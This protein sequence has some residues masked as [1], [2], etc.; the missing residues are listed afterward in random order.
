MTNLYTAHNLRVIEEQAFADIAPFALMQKAASSILAQILALSER[1]SSILI[2]AGRGNNGGDGLVLAALASFYGIEATVVLISGS[3]STGTLF[4]EAKEYAKRALVKVELFCES[5]EYS[6]SLL[7]DA[8]LG[9]GLKGKP[10]GE[11]AKAIKKFNHSRG[12]KISCDVPSG[13]CSDTGRTYDG[14]CVRADFTVTFIAKKVGLV[15]GD[16]FDYSGK[17]ILAPLELAPL[18]HK[19]SPQAIERNYLEFVNRLPMRPR[20][21]HK[22]LF[23]HVVVVAGSET[24]AGAALLAC[25]AA[26]RVGAGLVTLV[27][28][29]SHASSLHTKLAELMII[30]VGKKSKAWQLSSLFSNADV[31]L[32]GPG[33]RENDLWSEERLRE[34]LQFKGPKVLDAGGLS[35]LAKTTFETLENTVITPHPGEAKALLG[36][37]LFNDLTRIECVQELAKHYCATVV[38]KGAGPL[39]YGREQATPSLFPIANSALATAGSG[40]VFAG[41][42]AGFLAQGLSPNESAH[43]ALSLQQK[44]LEGML[45]EKGEAASIASDLFDFLPSFLEYDRHE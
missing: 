11:Y 14:L 29:H 20:N 36:E 22:G 2:F 10:R 37:T 31:L 44:A 23:G 5:Q 24:M 16:G 19:N 9:I 40:D 4:N 34:S 38:L 45:K 21:S 18:H 30:G 1:P 35:L 42:I 6:A 12:Q 41:L 13:L 17:V 32:C 26:L 43:L 8:M 3:G 27:T 28:H 39:V 7:V 15:T 25:E 33:L